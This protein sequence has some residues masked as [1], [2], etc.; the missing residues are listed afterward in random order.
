MVNEVLK[1]EDLSKD[2]YEK[3]LSSIVNT[4][5][6]ELTPKMVKEIIQEMIKSI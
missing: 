6:E 5:L 4:R 3:K 2:V 1:S